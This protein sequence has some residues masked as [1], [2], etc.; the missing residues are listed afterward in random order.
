VVTDR[1][2]EVVCHVALAE[3]VLCHACAAL[4][5]IA[6]K[7][8]KRAGRG[9]LES[10]WIGCFGDAAGAYEQRRWGREDLVGVRG[11]RLGVGNGNWW[12]CH[13]VEG[14]RAGGFLWKRQTGIVWRL[15]HCES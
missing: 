9:S 6:W 10:V 8:E 7:A 12:A 4:D 2:D 13:S 11:R 14:F 3:L 1:A 5:V 15:R